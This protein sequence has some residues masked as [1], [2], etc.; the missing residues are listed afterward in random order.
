MPDT[1]TLNHNALAPRQLTPA[2]WLLLAAVLVVLAET[3]RYF[4]VGDLPMSAIWPVSGLFIGATAGLGYRALSVLVPAL[5]LWQIG[6]QGLPLVT[7][8]IVAAGQATGAAVAVWLMHRYWA[9]QSENRPLGNQIALYTRC[10]LVGGAVVSAMGTLSLTQGT[11]DFEDARFHDVWL[12]YWAFEALGIILFAPLVFLFLWSPHR[13]MTQLRRDWSSPLLQA[14]LGVTLGVTALALI[15]GY[16]DMTT[17]STAVGFA[18]FPLLCWFVLQTRPA[19]MVL[20]VPAFA[21]LFMGFSLNE[22][23]GLPPI[24]AVPDLIRSL[25]LV[26]GLAVMT[27]VIAAISTERLRLIDRFQQQARSDYLTG[28]DNDRAFTR[29]LGSIRSHPAEPAPPAPLWLCFL[30]VLEAD[31][32]E[33]LLGF[34]DSQ[35]L[36]ILLSQRLLNTLDTLGRPARIGDGAYAMMVKAPHRDRLA[37][38]L[39]HLYRQ[40]DGQL[41]E[42]GEHQTRIR[43]ALGAVPLDGSLA[44]PSHY[45]SAANQV[46]WQAS[47]Q[48]HRVM[49]GDDIQ[50]LMAERRR[51]IEQLE[52]LKSALAEDRLEL[53]AQLIHP[54]DD[55]G[56]RLHYEI[57]LRLR[58]SNG[59]LL[60][61]GVFLPV[62]ETFGFM[63][64]IDQWVIRRTLETLAH[65]PHWLA[66]TA[67]CAINLAGSSLANPEL[68]AFIRAQLTRTGVAPQRICFEITETERIQ[69]RA[70]A[71]RMVQDLRALGCSVSLD[72]FGTGL[73]SFDYLRSF[74]LDY[75]KI[76]GLFIRD[77]LS[78]PHDESM[79]RAICSVAQGM[80]LRT[81]AEFV[82]DG[83]VM[84]RLQRI[85]VNYG[86]GFGIHRPQP[87]AELFAD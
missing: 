50:H 39:E 82:E 16:R 33:D 60:G 21:A 10:A 3:S 45:L 42:P 58:A 12:V 8:L 61:P 63:V 24:Q 79:V 22:M 71:A 47:R 1:S 76:D 29:R 28:L 80:G 18:F 55:D 64:E 43:V 34:E 15:M 40:F 2:G 30:Q 41:L 5:V 84:E 72:D 52:Q 46:V 17:Y 32:F 65:H 23:A 31:Q 37:E 11:A 20:A 51:S 67:K 86:Q 25:L 53:F 26:G 85:G 74:E 14:W 62:A 57:L 68:I 36:E 56:S 87:L 19:N 9:G 49:I 48:S 59:A 27:Q 13:F 54:F 69:E 77:I 81:I 35:K 83:A 73:A 78:N 38:K 4:T 7:A 70:T 75:V 6:L 66:R 44:D